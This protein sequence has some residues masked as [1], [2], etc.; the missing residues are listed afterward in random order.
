MFG[1]EYLKWVIKFSPRHDLFIKQVRHVI[2]VTRLM[3]CIFNTII[4]WVGFKFIYL[5]H[6]YYP[7]TT[8]YIPTRFNPLTALCGTISPI[9]D[10]WPNCFFF[11]CF[12]EGTKDLNLK[13]F[14]NTF[15]KKKITRGISPKLELLDAFISYNLIFFVILD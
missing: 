9:A 14:T 11:L 4:K 6:V 3:V 12:I 1:I 2:E 8:W 13:T 10:F 5:W 7:N 15:F